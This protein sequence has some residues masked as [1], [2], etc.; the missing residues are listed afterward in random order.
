[1]LFEKVFGMRI[2]F[3]K[4]E[5]IPMNLEVDQIHEIAHVLSCPMGSL[6]FKYL[7]VPMHYEKLGG[8][9]DF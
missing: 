1:M 6:P 9:A 3:N 7:G 5:F 8:E 2:N 4:S